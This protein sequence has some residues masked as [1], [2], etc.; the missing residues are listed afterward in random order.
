M[1]QRL[2]GCVAALALAGVLT[3]C[4]DGT[5]GA[6]VGIQCVQSDL[7][8]QCPPGSDPNFSAEAKTSCEAAGD[9][10]LIKQNGSVSGKCYGEG[11][12]IV[13]CQFDEPC[14]CGVD[15]ITDDGIVCTKC[16]EQAAC[17]NDICEGGE[18]AA[19]CPIDCGAVCV[20]DRQRCQGNDRETCNLAGRWEAVACGDGQQCQ[21][22]GDVSECVDQ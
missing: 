5:E 16:T 2:A 21:Q 10:D 19:S 7:I 6:Q 20:T 3:S 14:S 1:T 4:D 22:N 11:E 18:D 9:A 12:C 13:L 8:D 17:G 15:T